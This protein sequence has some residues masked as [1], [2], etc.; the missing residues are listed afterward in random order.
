MTISWMVRLVIGQ[1]IEKAPLDSICF[2]DVWGEAIYRAWRSPSAAT[3]E[4]QH[5][6]LL[7]AAASRCGAVRR[8]V[9]ATL[10]PAYRPQACRARPAGRQST[11][12]AQY[13]GAQSQPAPAAGMRQ[14]GPT[15][16]V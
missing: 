4:E 5:R 1:K 14:S 12:Q 9:C 7:T 16:P 8:V 13:R 15:R 10:L 3:E 2:C 6:M 11:P